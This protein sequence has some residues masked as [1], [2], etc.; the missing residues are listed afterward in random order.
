[1]VVVVPA[2]VR[3]VAAAAALVEDLVGGGADVRLV[4]RHPGPGDLR[5]G[6]VADAVNAPVV[7]VWPWERRLGAVVDGGR[8]ARAWRATAAAGVA[9]RLLDLLQDPVS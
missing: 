5:R 2:E 8:L 3:A 7:A 9:A 1:V 4:V 6:D